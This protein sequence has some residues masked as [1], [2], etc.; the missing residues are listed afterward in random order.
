VEAHLQLA[1]VYARLHQTELSARERKIVEE[2]NE[3]ARVKGP[4]PEAIP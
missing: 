4:Q 1:M 3:K 2:L